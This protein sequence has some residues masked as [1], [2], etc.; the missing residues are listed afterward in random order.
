M[1]SKFSK[2]NVV[3]LRGNVNLPI[4]EHTLLFVRSVFAKSETKEDAC[5]SFCHLR[6]DDDT[7]IYFCSDCRGET[8]FLPEYYIED[9]PVKE[10]DKPM[11]E[12]RQTLEMAS[13][14]AEL[15]M[16]LLEEIRNFKYALLGPRGSRRHHFPHR[17]KDTRKQSSNQEETPSKEGSLFKRL[18]RW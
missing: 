14:Q 2:G 4:P 8:Y 18:T 16:V 15:G 9:V 17:G 6:L 10:G 12:K 7:P 3:E 11:T 5:K 13:S 1:A